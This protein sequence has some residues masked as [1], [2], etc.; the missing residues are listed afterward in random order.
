MDMKPLKLALTVSLL[1]LAGG[2]AHAQD[3][4]AP[5]PGTATQAAPATTAPADASTAA[6]TPSADPATPPSTPDAQAAPAAPA[7]KTTPRLSVAP[8]PEEQVAPECDVTP[9]EITTLKEPQYGA[10]SNMWDILYAEEGMDVFTDLVPVDATSVVAGGA[11]TKDLNDTVYH[12]LLIKYDERLKPV[13]TVRA[14]TKEQ[15]TIHRIIKTKDGFTVLGDLND[16]AH[17]NGI[18]I[19]AY[20][21][22][23]KEKAKPAPIFEKGGDLDA[24]AFVASQDGSGYIIAAQFIDDKD[25]EK[26]NGFLYK[27]SKSGQLIWKRSYPTGRSNVFNNIQTALDGSYIVTGQIVLEGNR[28]G[29]WLIRV[30]EQGA[31]KW[32]RSYPRG[33]AA[34][35]QS[36]AQTKEG[37]LVL[38]GKA[39][40]VDYQGKGLSAWVMKTDSTGNPLWQRYFRGVYSYEAPDVIV[41][42]DGRASVLFSGAGLDSERRSHAR[43]VTFSPQGRVMFVEDFTDGQNAAATRLVAGLNGERIIVG[44]AQTSFGED[45]ESNEASAA[46]EYT[47]DA[48]LLAG[49]PLETFNDPCAPAPGLSPIL[50]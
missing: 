28:S 20:T 47:Y 17:G 26:Q 27:I 18:Y 7:S 5:A 10:A 33:L 23:G 44:H 49:V 1:A 29:G 16:S 41:Y 39:R 43:L 15:Q 45:Q 2:I 12:P 6:A 46:P 30:D 36:A 48:W 25:Q 34:S 32:Q 3:A 40:P 42:E 37:D 13:W 19:A 8:L 9:A 14:D 31:I 35:L 4:A 38:S 24:K 22:D 50:P 21:D 11:Y